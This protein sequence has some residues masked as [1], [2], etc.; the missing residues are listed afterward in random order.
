MLVRH[1]KKG[2]RKKTFL[3]LATVIACVLLLETLSAFLGHSNHGMSRSELQSALLV[4]GDNPSLPPEDDEYNP[5]YTLH[6]Y[7]GYSL[8]TPEA[9]KFGFRGPEPIFERRDGTVVVG[10]FGGSVSA[11][12]VHSSES[13]IRLLQASSVFQGRKIEI[14]NFALPG[15]KQPQQLITLAYFLSL[16]AQ[17]DIAINLDGYNEASLPAE[18]NVKANVYPFFPRNWHLYSR[19]GFEPDIAVEIGN[20]R[21][22]RLQQEKMRS[23]FS[24]PIL[25]KSN[26][27][28][29]L[30]KF[31]DLKLGKKIDHA[32]S[33]LG[34]LLSDR[35]HGPF[36]PDE[37]FDQIIRDSIEMWKSGSIQMDK[38][39]DA[40]DIAYFHF[41]QPTQLYLPKKLSIKEKRRLIDP[42]VHPYREEVKAAYP[43]LVEEGRDL[44]NRGVH[45]YDLTQ[46]FES[47]KESVYLDMVHS[48]PYGKRLITNAMMRAVI[49]Y[50][51]DH[52]DSIH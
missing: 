44:K 34:V 47:V 40:N 50:F 27:F 49:D 29:N 5:Q 45:F 24:H 48:N 4:G 13:M 12:L 39:C 7:Q 33:R 16:G 23:A 3:L 1:S 31:I 17:I 18:E 28:L 2:A 10:I 14:I 15:Y 42:K 32:N 25:R 19:K 21:N 52:P 22:H 37:D 30:W 35:Q 9:N 36:S 51:E 11:F 8:D 38:L 26:F 20:I 46:I 6:P 41:L 43:L